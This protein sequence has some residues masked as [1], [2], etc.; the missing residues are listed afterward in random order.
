VH[1]S[2]SATAFW[3]P[4]ALVLALTVILLL[5][6]PRGS[7]R[8]AQLRSMPEAT[9]AYVRIS[10]PRGMLPDPSTLD[11]TWRHA[12]P[13]DE[14]EGM[15]PRRLPTPVY[16]ETDTLGLWGPVALDPQTVRLPDLA[17]WPVSP[18]LD[19]SAPVTNGIAVT[20][21]PALLQIGFHFDVPTGVTTG[22]S[23]SVRFHV[24]VDGAGRVIHLLS[25]SS[26]NPSGARQIESALFLGRAS[27]AGS[28]Q[29]QVSWG[30]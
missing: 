24:E 18:L 1:V 15:A 11:G 2:R 7:H 20:L 22:Q 10:G 6:W 5:L 9:A 30:R 4:P 8:S 27:R 3:T 23:A 28:G 25:E 16:L 14:S 29:V 21:S 17:A 13:L 26:E 12:V 19:A